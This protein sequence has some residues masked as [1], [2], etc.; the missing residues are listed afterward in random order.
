MKNATGWMTLA[1]SLKSSLC[2]H[3]R[4]S[5][6]ALVQKGIVAWSG[7]R[8]DPLWLLYFGSAD[9]YFTYALLFLGILLH[10]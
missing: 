10:A 9:E 3:C 4:F 6:N 8:C 7:H 2:W 5:L 1:S